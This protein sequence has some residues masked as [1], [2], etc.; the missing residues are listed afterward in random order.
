MRADRIAWAAIPFAAALA[1]TVWFSRSMTGEMAMVGGWTMMVAMMLP[2]A[3]PMLLRHRRPGCVAVGCFSF[4]TALGAPI[5]L[6][7]TALGGPWG[8]ECAVAGIA[9]PLVRAGC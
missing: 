3:L 2:S 1:A 6:V 8:Q 7:R 9:P 4:W 5:Y